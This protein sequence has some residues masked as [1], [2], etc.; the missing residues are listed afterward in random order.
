M[1]SRPL[2][3]RSRKYSRQ[4]RLLH[5][6]WSTRQRLAMCSTAWVAPCQVK[7]VGAASASATTLIGSPLGQKRV[8]PYRLARSA[9]AAPADRQPG[10][11]EPRARRTLGDGRPAVPA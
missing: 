7:A 3:V 8:T 2:S 4:T 11:L 9:P 5:Q 6:L 1:T 10:R